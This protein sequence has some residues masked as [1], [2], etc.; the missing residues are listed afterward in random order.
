MPRPRPPLRAAFL[1]LIPAALAASPPATAAG[2]DPFDTG[3]LVPGQ[4]SRYWEG[5]DAVPPCRLPATPVAA[6]TLLEALDLALCANPQTR[7]S[8][9]A[10]RVAAA[11]VGVAR[12]G[13]L[14]NVSGTA[15]AQRSDTRN[16]LTAGTR[17]QLSGSVSLNYLL[18]D[19]G[20]RDATLAQARAALLAADWAHNGT[21]QSVLLAT[22]DAY[23]ALHAGEEAVVA[24]TTAERAAQQSL[25][26]ARARQSAGAATRADVLQAQTALSQARL[27]RT[28][29]EGDAATAR[30]TLANR[31]GLPA[32]T[33]IA[34]APPADLEVRRLGDAAVDSL[35][36]AALVRRPDLLAAEAGVRAA[37]A[38]VQVQEAAGKPSLSA[39]GTATGTAVNPGLDPRSATVGLTLTVPLFTGYQQTYRI[40]SA[41]EQ[42]AQQAATRDRLRNDAT[43]EVWSAYQGVRSQGQAYAAAGDLV[44]SATE[45]YELALGRYRAGA[46][47]VTD[48]LN[49]QSALAAARTQRIQARYRWNVAKVTLARAVGALDMTL[50]DDARPAR[51]A[52][53]GGPDR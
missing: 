17:D 14:P 9:S 35:V 47:T 21:L 15:G 53:A 29:A 1:L 39:F 48:L 12:S 3:A 7:E 13:F 30:G 38:G 26:A 45:S 18:F 49:A 10:A 33:R 22:T 16:S 6:L 28:Q 23:Y 40:R 8:W 46:G 43:L 19:F 2:D 20:G 4:P 52:N 25:D 44:A 11:Q 51:A 37:E 5:S 24:A 32:T 41:R 50:F 36:Q 27:S 31:V 34:I 42:V